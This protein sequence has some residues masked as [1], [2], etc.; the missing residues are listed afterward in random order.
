[1]G[2]K[3]PRGCLLVIPPGTGKTL[4]ARRCGRSRRCHFFKSISGSD[5]VEMF[6]G[7]GAS[8][9]RDLFQQA[10]DAA[11]SI[12]FIDEIDAVSRQRSA[13]LGGGHDDAS[14]HSTNCS[15]RWTFES[16]ESVIC[17]GDQPRRHLDPA[18][19]RPVASTARLWSTPPTL[20]GAGASCGSTRRTS[21]SAPTST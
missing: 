6:V 9:V 21:R 16:N 18:L 15:S 7:V 4:L 2:A 11:P 14:E 19:L 10:K 8:R 13:G 5:F 3:V 20:R 17:C 12:I 1:M